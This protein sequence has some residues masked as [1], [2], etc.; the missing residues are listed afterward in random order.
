MKRTLTLA[1]GALA[2]GLA[3]SVPPTS[4]GGPSAEPSG[5]QVPPDY[6]P[7][8]SFAP[9][10]QSVAP[11]VLAIETRSAVDLPRR[12]QQIPGLQDRIQQG[13]GSAFII[14]GDG[15]VLTNAHVVRGAQ[16]LKARLS[17]GTSVELEVLG[18]DSATDI[19][20]ARL[21]GDRADWPYVQLGSSGE[22]QVG[23]WVLAMGNPLGMGMTATAG[24]VSAKGRELGHDQ[25]GNED[26][27]QTDAAINM[28]NSGGPLFSTDGTVVGMNTAIVAGA[29]TIGFAIAADAIHAV[30]DDLQSKGHVSRGFLGIQP[31]DLTPDLAV[32]FGVSTTEGA[33]V[34]QVIEDTPAAKSGLRRGD[35]V[36]G[37]D[38]DPI[39]SG[40]DLV[41]AVA[42][43]RPGERVKLQVL[44]GSKEQEIRIQL[45]ERPTEDGAG[46]GT[47][48]EPELLSELGVGLNPLP[49]A[50]ALALD[51]DQGVLVARVDRDGAF[52]GRLRPG[53]VILEVNN[54]A[55]DSPEEVERILKRSGHN[56]Y[57]LVV[58]DNA[59][60][61]VT[62]SLP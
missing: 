46:P 43:R 56:A 11:A 54:R 7:M 3:L 29:N 49:S 15:L 2:V 21:A 52:A 57:F 41:V 60:L 31:Q 18:A 42:N 16:S 17:D 8:V 39:G 62:V 61:F 5:A 55:T 40:N 51:V 28:G 22:L 4:L 33:L 12:L 44:R 59:Q 27:I 10:V 24:I 20:V 34:A 6:N 32:A 30:L 38:D 48:P 1:A 13:E 25:F 37:V 23:D 45:A 19:A 14:S 50:M 47:E 36:I 53:D 9:L 35:V 26:F 58:R